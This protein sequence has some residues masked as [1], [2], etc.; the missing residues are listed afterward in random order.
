M[1]ESGKNNETDNL[2]HI[3]ETYVGGVGIYQILITVIPRLTRLEWQPKNRVKR[4]S[5]YASQNETFF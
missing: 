2:D 5:R 3:L 1:E 4:N